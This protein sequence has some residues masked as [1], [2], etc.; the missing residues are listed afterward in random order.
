MMQ[1]AESSGRA[2]VKNG[3]RYWSRPVFF[4]DQI[5]PSI[6]A[7]EEGF[8]GVTSK[9]ITN[10]LYNRRDS[11]AG[12]PVR[13][14]TVKEA[15]ELLN[16]ELVEPFGIPLPRKKKKTPAKIKR[17]RR[18]GPSLVN[19]TRYFNQTEFRKKT[20]TT[21]RAMREMWSSGEIVLA[22]ERTVHEIFEP[23]K[24]VKNYTFEG[25]VW[26]DGSVTIRL[27]G[28]DFSMTR[29]MISDIPPEMSDSGMCLWE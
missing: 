26:A 20:G 13:F 7:V 21:Q 11:A 3:N 29:R 27:P 25:V 8:E 28:T 22:G 23:K 4:S 18:R 6:R 2:F 9:Q 24:V 5:F 1:V 19:G 12:E 16:A 10:A 14:A 15:V 17:I